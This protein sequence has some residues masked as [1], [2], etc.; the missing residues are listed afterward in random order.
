MWIWGFQWMVIRGLNICRI[1]CA[2]FTITR[3]VKA[4]TV[5]H[6]SMRFNSDRDQSSFQ[7]CWVISRCIWVCFSFLWGRCT[8]R[9]DCHSSTTTN[10][11]SPNQQRNLL[12]LQQHNQYQLIC[13]I[14]LITNIY[15][16]SSSMQI[17][18][19]C[20]CS[21]FPTLSPCKIQSW[22]SYLLFCWWW[23]NTGFFGWGVS[24]NCWQSYT[25]HLPQCG[26]LWQICYLT[27][28]MYSIPC[29]NY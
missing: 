21:C 8:L 29:G 23:A 18:H 10:C 4:Q 5:D 17:Q 19:Y 11:S 22:Y 27:K 28:S 16:N 12:S 14:H 3:N 1:N 7:C 2:Y 13:K 6:I 24:R 9:I 20:N 26:R 25:I 15:L